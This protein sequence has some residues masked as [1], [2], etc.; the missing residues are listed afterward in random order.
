MSSRISASTD[1]LRD[2]DFWRSRIGLLP[3]PLLPGSES[4]FVL[5]NGTCGNFCLDIDE[6]R[7]SEGR[8]SAWSS[9]VGHYVSLTDNHVSVRPWNQR[10]SLTQRF[11]LADVT[12]N[13][14]KFHRL[15]EQNEPNRDQSIVA[16]A[17]RVLAQLRTLLPA[18]IGPSD[19]VEHFLVLLGSAMEGC[20]PADLQRDKW[21]LDTR[22][23]D[24]LRTAE[25]SLLLRELTQDRLALELKPHLD[26]L[27]RHASGALFQEA[28]YRAVQPFTLSLPGIPPAPSKTVKTSAA[29]SGVYFTPPSLARTIVEEALRALGELPA[30]LR[31]FDPA[32]GSG[33]F[34]KES[35]RQLELRGYTGELELIGWDVLEAPARMSRFS[36]AYEARMTRSFRMTYQI[37][38]CNSL[39]RD[40]W[41]IGAMT[42]M[43]PPFGSLQSL[44]PAMKEKVTEIAGGGRPNLASAF[45]IRAIESVADGGVLG[46]VIPS[47]VT[48]AQSGRQVRAA[49]ASKFRPTLVGKLGSQAVFANAIVDAGLY[50]GVKE[51]VLGKAPSRV[52][53]AD[54]QP[55]SISRALRT[56]RRLSANDIL[57][58]VVDTENFSVYSHELIGRN[59]ESWT[60]AP[61]RAVARLNRLQGLP[62]L[63]KIFEIKQGVRLGNDV[64][65]ISRSELEALP[66]PEQ[67]F[68]RPAVTNATLRNSRVTNDWHVWFPDSRNLP[69]IASEDDLKREVPNYYQRLLQERANLVQRS[70]VSPE[71]WWKLQRSRGWQHDQVPK[72]VTTYFGDAGSV[73][74][75]VEGTFAVV[76]GHAWIPRV[77]VTEHSVDVAFAYVAIAAS[78]MFGE[79]LLATSTQI[80]GGQF[81]LEKRHID[82][83]PMVDL[84]RGRVPKATRVAL[85]QL[86]EAL[87]GG[88]KVDRNELNHHSRVIFGEH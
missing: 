49:L 28:H 60:P 53:W 57:S 71:T 65:L 4:S 27:L 25:W 62:T 63:G 56:V 86:G 74:Y 36:L 50:V 45:L 33:E 72:L 58:D 5:L 67:R 52:V 32:C 59:S 9:D 24:A 6:D 39:E 16:H 79:L 81:S 83:L 17:L 21:A 61:Y 11:S 18:D 23:P 35:I 88:H 82:K 46:A 37:E 51:P 54:P 68:F 48:D 41:P 76:V 66:L 43:N 30:K 31:V 77:S 75:D 22:A 2:P 87:T 34:L 1:S 42:L 8:S 7:E 10:R 15:L 38:V 80:A 44:S 78:E 19:V 84:Y 29:G 13:L 20:V 12:A 70:A 55:E 14:D 64:F 40:Q 85:T 69:T 73:A 3:V 47:A 26:L